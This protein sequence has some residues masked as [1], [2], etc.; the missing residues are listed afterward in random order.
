MN[1]YSVIKRKEQ[2]CKYV[3]R[4]MILFESDIKVENCRL[5]E[6]KIHTRREIP[7]EQNILAFKIEIIISL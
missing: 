7:N 3:D 5:S 4:V 2:I 1:I 6:K